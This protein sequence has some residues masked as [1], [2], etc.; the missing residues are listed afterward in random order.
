MIGFSNIVGYVSYSSI[1]YTSVTFCRGKVKEEKTATI[2][3][4][5]NSYVY[6]NKI[7][8]PIENVLY[9]KPSGESATIKWIT[10]GGRTSAYVTELQK[11]KL[12]N[13]DG[14]ALKIVKVSSCEA[15]ASRNHSQFFTKETAETIESH[16]APKDVEEETRGPVM[17]THSLL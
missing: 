6:V 10:V 16:Y 7:S 1:Y 15:I 5:S 9:R 4:S 17:V 13:V 3:K 2:L 12:S 11:V 14:A 8:F